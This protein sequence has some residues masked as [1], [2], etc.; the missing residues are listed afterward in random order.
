MAER[1]RFGKSLI[2]MFN[3]GSSRG[4]PCAHWSLKESALNRT[5]FSAPSRDTDCVHKSKTRYI[6][7]DSDLRRRPTRI[8]M[9]FTSLLASKNWQWVS[10]NGPVEMSLFLQ[11]RLDDTCI[12]QGLV[13][14]SRSIESPHVNPTESEC[15][16]TLETMA[17]L[18]VA[19]SASLAATLR[20][21]LPICRTGNASQLASALSMADYKFCLKAPCC[22]LLP[23]RKPSGSWAQMIP[24]LRAAVARRQLTCNGHVKPGFNELPPNE[25]E[26]R[27][28]LPAFSPDM[29]PA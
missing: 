17:M 4:N 15:K 22:H 3:A 28:L 24:Q 9:D 16:S 2:H 20:D 29:P 14:F 21:N 6:C 8:Q 7:V 12:A 25:K 10:L 1:S 27:S 23:E 11:I 18:V 5:R 26:G 19:R 13:D